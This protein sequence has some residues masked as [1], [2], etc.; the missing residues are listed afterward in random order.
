MS[1]AMKVFSR[2]FCVS[3]LLFLAGRGVFAQDPTPNQPVFDTSPNGQTGIQVFGSYFRADIDTIG[4]CNGNIV[5]RIPLISL[6]GREIALSLNVAYNSQKW[7]RADCGGLSCGEY[8][9][10]W[11][12]DDPTSVPFRGQT[13]PRWLVRRNAI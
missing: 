3:I 12:I 9:G 1:A 6:S 11:R 2:T 8:T 5:L 7:E 4:L 10:G 13:D